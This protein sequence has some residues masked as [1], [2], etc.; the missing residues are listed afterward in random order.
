MS[1]DYL[2]SLL[3]FMPIIPAAILCLCPV[4][5]HIRMS[6][7]T[8]AA[9]L[10]FLAVAVIPAAAYMDWRF[11]FDYNAVELPLI[12]LLF[13]VYAGS[14]KLHISRSLFIY[15]VVNAL[16][17]FVS[18]ASI[19]FD[20]RLNP[21]SDLEHFSLQAAAFQLTLSLVFT[22]TFAFPIIKYGS[23]L[24]NNL[25]ITK[26]WYTATGISAIFV[27]FNLSVVIHYYSTLSFNHV[28]RAYV[29]LLILMFLLMIL[30]NIVFYYLVNTLI[31]KARVEEM[32]HILA[33]Q[34]NHYEAQQQYIESTLRSRHDFK[35][36]IRTLKTLSD[37][38]DLESIQ[39]YIDEYISTIPE[40]TMV[41]YCHNNPL[42][43][44]LN[45]YAQSAHANGISISICIDI[46]DRISINSVDLC[47]ILGNILEN[48]IKGCLKIPE[49]KRRIK[50][51]MQ[52]RLN[53]E[54]YIA[55][56]NTFDGAIIPQIKRDLSDYTSI[57]K[58]GIGMYSIKS[59]VRKYDGSVKFYP[60]D[61]EFCCD[62]VMPFNA[63]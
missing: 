56:S 38:S 50:L 45:Y 40:N 51:S 60:Y 61:E 32:N 7:K 6:V 59:T 35:H 12:I 31:E 62:I 27:V 3:S 39:K 48:S 30:L 29:T 23:Y 53:R 4:K 13:F 24:I 10:T 8:M 17:G 57:R 44:L 18:N 33:M 2:V 37:N 47:M 34:E 41:T 14:L 63:D 52:T 22:A 21:L 16:M 26:I 42:N 36:A 49:E 43:A 1:N 11:G 25:Q 58:D 55:A 15:M 5:D 54:L 20:A 46:P 9:S 28:G 19:V